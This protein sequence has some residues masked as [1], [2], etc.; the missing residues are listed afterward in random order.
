[1]KQAP[2]LPKKL[3]PP[4]QNDLNFIY[5]SW[6]NSYLYSPFNPIPGNS[7][8]Y[9]QKLL[10]THILNKSVVSV[11]CNPDDTDQ[12]Y[13]YAVYQIK[14]NHITLHWLYIKLTFRQLGCARYI[15]DNLLALVPDNEITITHK[16]INYEEYR[17]KFNHLYIPKKAFK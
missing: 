1:M 2:E 3:R 4:N 7:Y 17:D 15:M 6:L 10:I 9:Y 5:A 12:I 8:Y 16:G 13:G 14:D 11:L